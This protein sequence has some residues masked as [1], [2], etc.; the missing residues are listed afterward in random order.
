[1]HISQDVCACVCVCI[2]VYMYLNICI[3]ICICEHVDVRVQHTC[4]HVCVHSQPTLLPTPFPSWVAGPPGHCSW[5]SLLSLHTVGD[6]TLVHSFFS[7]LMRIK[8]P[9]LYLQ[10]LTS[11]PSSFPIDNL[12]AS[13]TQWSQIVPYHPFPQ[14][15]F[16]S[17]PKYA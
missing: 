14:T 3:R 6:I 8:L 1:M 10:P 11:F 4:L 2:Y 9:N 12:C 15:R 17:S 7:S 16:P 5:A 13:R